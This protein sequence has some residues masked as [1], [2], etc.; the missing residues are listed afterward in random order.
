MLRKFKITIDGKTYLVEMEE[1]GGTP[2]AAAPTPAPAAAPTPAAETPAPAPAAPT[3]APATP[4]AASGEGEV[5]T[6][7][8]PGTVTKI[9]VKSGDAV[10][11]NQPLMI[12]EAMKMENEIVAPKTGTVGDIIATLNQS[13]N[14]GD[15]LISII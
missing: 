10:T 5:V 15:G 13:V 3:P 9:L 4:A 14:S 8:M 7:P 2:A 6:A 12:L 11:E 1:I